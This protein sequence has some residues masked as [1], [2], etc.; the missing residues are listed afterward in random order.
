MDPAVT[1]G[2]RRGVVVADNGLGVEVV[3]HGDEQEAQHQDE[4]CCLMVETEERTVN[5][6]PRM[7]EPFDNFAQ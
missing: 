1:L 7:L 3:L 4:G 2:I 5:D 6:Q